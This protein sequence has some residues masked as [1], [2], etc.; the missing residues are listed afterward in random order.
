MFY[1][2]RFSLQ[3]T[4]ILLFM[5]IGQCIYRAPRFSLVPEFDT[6]RYDAH[7]LEF[8]FVSSFFVVNAYAFLMRFFSKNCN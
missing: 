4:S 7:T 6:F 5:K 2:F 1:I 8:M 3:R